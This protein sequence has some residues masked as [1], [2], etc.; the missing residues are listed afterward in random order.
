MAEPA[1]KPIPSLV[2]DAFRDTQDLVSKEIALFRA[3]ISEGLRQLSTGL[4]L[5]IAAGVFA[6]TGLFVLILALVKALAVLLNSEA[7][8]ALIVGG[9]FALIAIALALW[10]RS[11]ASL[12][13]LEPTRTERQLR[14]DAGIITE[15]VG[16]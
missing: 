4:M 15:R 9:L 13:S 5:L 12:S 1:P 8:A 14:Q 3:E 2:G 7:L 10:G 16:E 11:K 6:V